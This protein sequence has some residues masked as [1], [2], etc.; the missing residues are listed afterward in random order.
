MEFFRK[1]GAQTGVLFSAPERRLDGQL[2]SSNHHPGFNVLRILSGVNYRNHDDVQQI[3]CVQ[4]KVGKRAHHAAPDPDFYFD[5]DFRIA[6]DALK[7]RF[8]LIEKGGPQA[9]LLCLMPAVSIVNVGLSLWSKSE[10]MGHRRPDFSI[11]SLT[12]C[13]SDVAPGFFR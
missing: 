6:L 11:R 12:S 7:R 10:P 13:Q 2:R 9:C 8:G 1:P 4:H 3:D 5:V